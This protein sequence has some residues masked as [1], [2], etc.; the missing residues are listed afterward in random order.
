MH[1]RECVKRLRV[2]H[3]TGPPIPQSRWT[4]PSSLGMPR[5]GRECTLTLT[6]STFGIIPPLNFS[7]SLSLSGRGGGGSGLGWRS[8]GLL[9]PW[10]PL[11]S[12]P[13]EKGPC[14]C[15]HRSVC[16]PACVCVGCTGYQETQRERVC[17][18]AKQWP[19]FRPAGQ[20]VSIRPGWNVRGTHQWRTGIMGRIQWGVCDRMRRDRG[21]VVACTRTQERGGVAWDRGG[22]C[23]WQR[24]FLHLTEQ[25]LCPVWLR[26][27]AVRG[28]RGA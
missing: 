12:V 20:W 7:L 3:S 10:Q 9:S 21:R 4:L 5:V 18:W 11:P 2:Y 17:E 24:S 1:Q 13:V 14:V 22:E 26:N 27:A 28:D 19:W 15:P 23:V 16:V 6:H 8:V 25:C